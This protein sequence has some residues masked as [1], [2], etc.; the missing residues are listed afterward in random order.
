M[1]TSVPYIDPN[2]EHVGVSKLRTLNAT[3]LRQFEKAMVIQDNDT[4]LAVLLTYDQFLT[5]QA[6]LQSVI[7]TIELITDDQERAALVDGL[8]SVKEG[9][10]R[11]L[12]EIRA[13]LRKRAK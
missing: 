10:T 12:S 2:V 1:S 9:R 6:Q 4:P 11:P 7:E 5:M 3:T 8:R 13:D